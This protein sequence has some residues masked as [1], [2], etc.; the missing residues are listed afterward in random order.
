MADVPA[1]AALP[2]CTGPID[3]FV[4][5]AAVL[6]DAP[7]EPSHRAVIVGGTAHRPSS[8]IRRAFRGVG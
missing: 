4:H 7:G 8:A 3:R 2:G 5:P 6:R 1:A